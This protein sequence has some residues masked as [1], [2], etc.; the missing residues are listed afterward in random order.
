[1]KKTL[2]TA[3]LSASH[4]DDTIQPSKMADTV[5]SRIHSREIFSDQIRNMSVN[6]KETLFMKL[7]HLPKLAIVAIAIG[8][9]VLVSGSAYAIYSLWGHPDIQVTQPKESTSGR[10]EVSITFASCGTQVMPNKYELKKGATIDANQIEAVVKAQCE[11]KAINDWAM[12]TYAQGP[13]GTFGDA[14]TNETPSV[15]LARQLTSVNDSSITV[16]ELKQKLSVL[17]AETLEAPSSVRFIANGAEVARS[18]FKPGDPV[19]YVTLSKTIQTPKEQCATDAC[20]EFGEYRGV[21]RLVAVVKLDRDFKDYDNNALESLAELT[22]CIGNEKDLCL[23]GNAASASLYMHNGQ[24]S[25]TNAQMTK[26]IEGTVTSIT[27]EAFAIKSTSGTTFTINAPARI[28]TSFNTGDLAN[29]H[30]VT[31]EVGSTVIVRYIEDKTQH[32]TTISR[33]MIETIDF[34]LEIVTKGGDIHAY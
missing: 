10:Q 28:F 21:D 15:G 25:I 34:R 9:T 27:N 4:P 2:F 8:A 16:A 22:S 20:R 24:S 3:A 18:A 6:K 5:M 11:L 33:G 7:H 12:K 19:V 23:E 13:N 14:R 17:P 31:A 30:K 26:E 32:A 1:M 29:T